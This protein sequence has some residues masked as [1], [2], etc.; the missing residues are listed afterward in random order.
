M[1]R[2]LY[3]IVLLLIFGAGFITGKFAAARRFQK[4]VN[5]LDAD[6]RERVWKAIR[7]KV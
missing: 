2:I 3:L 4:W 7:G 6:L 1:Q 5:G